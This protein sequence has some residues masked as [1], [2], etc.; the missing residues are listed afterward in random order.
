MNLNLQNLF[1]NT[2]NQQTFEAGTVIFAERDRADSMYVVLDGEVDVRVG[3]NLLEV[4]GPGG[5]VGEMALIDRNTRSA[6]AM[7]KSACRLAFV[8]E[9]H[10]QFMVQQTPYFALHVMRVMADRLRRMNAKLTT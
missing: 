3:N 9:K 4:I 1:K 2:K 6:T 7:A 10:F 8:D 5:I